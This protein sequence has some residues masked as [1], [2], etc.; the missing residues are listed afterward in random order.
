MTLKVSNNIDWLNILLILIALSMAYVLPFSLFLVAY[1][2][3]GP[4]HYLTEIHWIR[5]KGFFVENRH[6]SWMAVSFALLI[7]LPP[8]AYNVL[9][10]DVEPTTGIKTF[11]A[12][13]GEWTNGL[14]FLALI[15]AVSFVLTSNRSI[16]L[17][18]L[19]SGI[20]I[21]ALINYLPFYVTLV[22]LLIPTIIHVYVFT[23]LFMLYGALKVKSKVG[24]ASVVLMVLVVGLVVVLP[25]ESDGYLFSDLVKNT[26]LENR[27]HVLNT[28]IRTLL[29]LSDGK[30]F[31]FYEQ[32]EL[33]VQVFITFAYVY[34]YLNWF[35]KTTVIG[36]HKRLTTARSTV[37]LIVWLLCVLLFWYDY[38][39]GFYTA[40]ALSFMHV[41]LEFPINA[42]SV[43]EISRHLAGRAGGA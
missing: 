11:M 30:S 42:I 34:H 16:H 28:E 40:L 6:W 41:L 35:S 18:A 23:I 39:V 21:A 29:G 24:Y 3:L 32:A 10:A 31:Y 19:A 17:I 12:L 2:V 37:I 14:I 4:L 1:A 33:K 8:V 7:A 13:L 27:F 20:C 15:M 36:W 22:G 38:K 9:L 25:I 43:R 5:T 26:F